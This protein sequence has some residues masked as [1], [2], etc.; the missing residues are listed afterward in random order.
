M[1][2][3]QTGKRNPLRT[4]VPG[5]KTRFSG[6]DVLADAQGDPTKVSTAIGARVEKVIKENPGK[7][8]E[9]FDDKRALETVITATDPQ[10][11]Q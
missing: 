6:A 8:V 3:A 1:T 10:N 4:V 11:P 7:K 9:V 2:E 5:E